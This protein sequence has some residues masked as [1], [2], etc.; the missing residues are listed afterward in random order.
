M[1]EAAVAASPTIVPV[2][3]C[4][5]LCDLVDS[6]ALTERLGDSA[7]VDAFRRHDRL[8]R[9]LL[10][11]AGGREVDKTDGFLLLFEHPSKAVGFALAYL[12]QLAELST[13][14]GVPLAA[15][16]G[17]HVGDVLVWE[18]VDDAA[19]HGGRLLEVEGLAKPVVARIASLAE[20]GQ[21]LLSGMAYALAQRSLHEVGDQAIEWRFHG[22]YRLKGVAKA[23]PVYQ[24]GE[25]RNA[26]FTRPHGNDKVTRLVPWWRRPPVLV[27]ESLALL[28]AIAVPFWLTTTS[29]PALAFAERDWVVIGG[30]DNRTG[31]STFDDA[32][33]RAFRISLEQSRFVNVMPELQVRDALARMNRTAEIAVDRGVA[34][35]I[36]LRD[37]ARAVILPSVAEIG[38]RVRFAVEVVDPHTQKTVYAESAD[39]SGAESVLASIDSVSRQLRGKLGEA[40]K[41]IDA[42]SEA[43]PKVSTSNL[44]ALRAYALAIRAHTGSHFSEALSLYEQAEKL[45]PGFALAYAGQARL[46]YAA[47]DRARAQQFLAK[48]QEHRDRLPARDQLY[49][50]AWQENFGNPRLAIEK[51]KLLAELYPDYYSGYYNA[52]LFTAQTTNRYAEAVALAQPALSAHCYF[53]RSVTYATGAFLLAQE[54]RAAA[55]ERFAEAERLGV[56]GTMLEYANAHLVARDYERASALMKR[57]QQGGVVGAD[58]VDRRFGITLPL[59]QGRVDDARASAWESSRIASTVGPAVALDW[60]AAAL[61]VDAIRA[62]DA[63]FIASLDKTLAAAVTVR[64]GGF[65]DEGSTA[66]IQAWLAYLDARSGTGRVAEAKVEEWSSNIASLGHTNAERMW[67]IAKAARLRRAGNL[68][69]ALNEIDRQVDG[70]ELFQTH[71][72]RMEIL[73]A[74]GRA[75]DALHEADWLSAHR[76][77][78]FVESGSHEVTIPLNVADANLAILRAA[79]LALA[80]G[81]KTIAKARL[82]EFE[83]VWPESV[84]SDTVRRRYAGVKQLIAASH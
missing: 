21:I 72:E 27:A 35:E 5:V 78:A 30:L 2:L 18:H 24:V 31:Q 29:E 65:Q 68:A 9:R 3:R 52:A 73:A 76:G 60:A 69:G 22:R 47:D 70:A 4:L 34:S 28:A 55:L 79:D 63:G 10:A 12:R 26:N 16:V 48:A 41:S 49:L 80:A 6:T 67:G 75:A 11:D 51:W 46:Y 83:R 71:V 64:S 40:V 66:F 58:L 56:G 54:K 8:A 45:D 13:E 33:D 39:G 38:G 32:L 59:D 19:E 1:S 17:V 20:P 36:A 7:A 50:D 37:G 61:G 23:M 43:L 57:A 77:L 62:P 15:R 81:E 25:T 74:S 14:I 53:R 44:D 42:N 82:E 84:H